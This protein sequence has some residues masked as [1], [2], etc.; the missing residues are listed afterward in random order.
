LPAPRTL[1]APRAFFFFNLFV[2]LILF[3]L[4][5]LLFF[6]IFFCGLSFILAFRDNGRFCF[7][8]KIGV[9]VFELKFFLFLVEFETGGGFSRP[10]ELFEFSRR[11]HFFVGNVEMVEEGKN[12][13]REN[14]LFFACACRVNEAV[15][16][17]FQFY[18]LELF[19][20]LQNVE[21]PHDEHEHV[22][23]I[24]IVHLGF[25]YV[26]L[27]GDVILFRRFAV[28]IF[29]FFFRLF[30]VL[31]L[32]FFVLKDGVDD[33]FGFAVFSRLLNQ[34]YFLFQIADLLAYF[35][36][37]LYF[38]LLLFFDLFFGHDDVFLHV[39]AEFRDFKQGI[40]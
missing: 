30:H 19:S 33:F 29:L 13:G 12:D 10:F 37:F 4:F 34:L 17:L 27:F 8:L 15:R 36:N 7:A 24:F 20:V 22:L 21:L 39:V 2:F 40:F 5:F 11:K 6:L 38:A 31:R 25:G 14:V 26:K 35:L 28:L 3:L 32:I 16:N 1:P 23:V 18:F 9:E